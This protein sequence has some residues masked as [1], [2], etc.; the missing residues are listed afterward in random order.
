[1]WRD[2]EI[3]R[4]LIG[5]AKAAGYRALVVTVDTPVLGQR[6]RDVRS[7]LVL[8]PRLTAMS[9]LDTLRRVSWLR[10][11]LTHPRPTFGNFVGT[12]GV[13]HDAISLATF[14]T[15][16]FSA[17]IGWDDIDWYRSL[18]PG[19][20]ALKGI[21]LPED[22]GRAA[23]R[24]VEAI[25]VSNHGGRQLDGAL[26]TID[27]LPGIAA[28]VAGRIPVLVDGG[29]RRGTDV[30]K[31]IALGAAAVLIGRP[32]LWGLAAAGEAGV[33]G[34]LDLLRGELEL[35]MALCGCPRIADINGS[36]VVRS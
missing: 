23:E 17:A 1:V 15:Q 36:L 16:Q 29:V 7:G 28:H 12:A 20:I 26:A 19:P 22:A 5:R 6:E 9:V 25:I 32:Y 21:M 24:G 18:W 11:F 13:S 27:A 31:A 34:V 2:R 14:T 10:G 8:P 33:R 35:A 4:M 3:V 30:L